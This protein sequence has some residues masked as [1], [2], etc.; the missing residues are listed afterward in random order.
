MCGP[1]H[2]QSAAAGTQAFFCQFRSMRIERE[3]NAF[4]GVALT[5]KKLGLQLAK[6]PWQLHAR[7]S[8]GPTGR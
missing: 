6:E 7:Q 2:I 1:S 4:K 5:E 3:A 8:G